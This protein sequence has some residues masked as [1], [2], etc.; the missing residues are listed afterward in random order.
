MAFGDNKARN[1]IAVGATDARSVRLWCRAE[2]PGSFAVRVR[3][4]GVDRTVTFELPAERD[5]TASVKYPDDFPGEPALA[6]GT[7]HTCTVASTDGTVMVGEAAFETAPG[8]AADT[9]DRFS[10]GLVSCHQPFDPIKGVELPQNLALLQQLPAAFQRYNTKL[11]LMM[12]DQMYADEPRPFSPFDPRYAAAV[13][14]GRSGDVFA[15]SA[16][17]VRAELQQRYRTFWA[18]LAWRKLMAMAPSYSIL[19]DH[20]CFDD[21]GSLPDAEAERRATFVRGARLAYMDYQGSKQGAW[22]GLDLAPAF[23]YELHYGTLAG[24]VFD[25]RSER[26]RARGR[27]LGDEQLARFRAFLARSTEAH[28]LLLVTSVPLV[29]IPEWL[30]RL[31]QALSPDIDFPDHWSAPH[32]LADRRRVIDAL[33]EHLDKPATA[34]QKVLVVGGDV[35]IGG[36]FV[37]RLVGSGRPIYQLT[38]SAV[39]NPLGKVK[40]LIPERWF[41]PGGPLAFPLWSRTSDNQLDIKLLEPRSGGPG[42]NPCT[43]LNAG[44]V[45]LERRGDSTQLRLKLLGQG[46][47][48][49]VELFESALL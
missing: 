45:E 11:N 20:E 10:I 31:G 24:F 28:V 15:W 39:S 34:R 37:M 32:N 18:P 46:P 17:E 38:S 40:G 41:A 12:G 42:K 7:R 33:R 27:V 6:A 30:T 49:A 29:H 2:R 26:S 35:H 19:D 1:L 48:G 8:E 21:W 23:D 9:P 13:A 14:P 4:P 43:D 36:A 5:Q 3:A 47:T 16:E 25:L 22:N 44:V